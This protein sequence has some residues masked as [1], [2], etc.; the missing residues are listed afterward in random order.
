MR[1]SFNK[2]LWIRTYTFTV[3][4]NETVTGVDHREGFYSPEIFIYGTNFSETNNITIRFVICPNDEPFFIPDLIEES[5]NND[6][7]KSSIFKD[8][9]NNSNDDNN[10]DIPKRE[11][12]IIRKPRG[13][14]LALPHTNIFNNLNNAFESIHDPIDP[15]APNKTTT[16]TT[17]ITSSSSNT[18]SNVFTFDNPN[19][20][21]IS[22][23]EIEENDN[24]NDETDKE[25]TKQDIQ[26]ISK[27][28][29][30]SPTTAKY[31][32]PLRH[33]IQ[34]NE[35]NNNNNNPEATTNPLQIDT[36]LESD[37][38]PYISPLH[39][40]TPRSLNHSNLS[41]PNHHHNHHR[42]SIRKSF[43]IP[44]LPINSISRN[45]S[46]SIQLTPKQFQPNL[47]PIHSPKLYHPGSM[48][49]L[50]KIDNLDDIDNKILEEQDNNNNKDIH[51]NN[52]HLDLGEIDY[53][54]S[55]TV[56]LNVYSNQPSIDFNDANYKWNDFI[57]YTEQFLPNYYSTS[58]EGIEESSY[59]SND[60]VFL[61]D[62]IIEDPSTPHPADT[63]SIPTQYNI[64]KE[65][66]T[67][68][69]N[70]SSLTK[71]KEMCN[72]PQLLK[73]IDSIVNPKCSHKDPTDPKINT[74]PYFNVNNEENNIYYQIM[75]RCI[76]EKRIV[77]RIPREIDT[78]T[79]CKI[80]LALN[81]QQYLYCGK[82]TIVRP[83]CVRQIV[84]NRSSKVYNIYFIYLLERWF[85]S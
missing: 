38:N 2:E 30:I 31:P 20:V 13:V 10:K 22:K 60:I 19:N 24:Q 59:M 3:Y 37:F 45:N 33:E 11:Q 63:I 71:A 23:I 80:Y 57:E 5:D 25:I 44:C 14:A 82:T 41:T 40:R 34:E 68:N 4:P 55:S 56:E 61:N 27:S 15:D 70:K 81:G 85:Y 79:V 77:C 51:Y 26:S 1:I 43:I 74:N 29:P 39:R 72:D 8:G 66:N 28:F 42:N 78:G 52:R 32:S 17:T 9:D 83:P 76:D 48:F 49:E 35:D 50:P 62:G 75:G 6:G 84:P 7:E 36:E 46:D 12:V 54:D 18:S 53:K 58:L 73:V 16:T 65:Y 69:Q 67:S 21:D 64:D 47:S